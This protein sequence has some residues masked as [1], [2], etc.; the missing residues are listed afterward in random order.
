MF[1]IKYVNIMAEQELLR[2]D[3][4]EIQIGDRIESDGYFGTVLYIGS[5]A[6][7]K[8]VWL[9]VEWD[10]SNRGKHD[11]SHQGKR[12]FQTSQP[13]SGSFIRPNKVKAGV[14]CLKAIISRYGRT[15]DENAGV[16]IEDL[17]VLSANKKQTVVEMVGAKKTN[18][19]Q[20]QLDLLQEVSLRDM[21]VYGAGVTP[22]ELLRTM[23]NIE[24]LDLS[25]NLIPSW[26]AV[27]SITEQLKNLTIL[28]VS[29]NKMVLPENPE[30]LSSSFANVR[31]LIANKMKYSWENILQ[32][33][34]ICPSLE[35]L[36]VCFNSIGHLFSSGNQLRQLKLLNLES[37][38]LHSWDELLKLG[39][40][41]FLEVLIV[42][43]NELDDIYFPDTSPCE[44]SKLFPS[45]K[46]LIITHNKVSKWKSIDELNKL[47]NLEKLKIMGNPLMDTANPETVR[48]L[49]IA[50]IRNL[51]RCNGTEVTEERKGAEIDYLKRYGLDWV[52]AG[53]SQDPQKNRPSQEFTN[54]HP[55]YQELIT[56][57][58][59][60]EDSELKQ[61]ST[62]LKSNLLSVKIYC[63]LM[64]DREPVEK[65][66]PASMTVQKLKALIQ[67]LYKV[68][69]E[70]Q[71]S[72]I[73][74]K[75]HGPEIELDSD[76]RQLSFFALETGDTVHVKW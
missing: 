70:V 25:K 14:N 21:L 39:S 22:E 28:N 24:D 44:K 64:P 17:Y 6:G 42:S 23:P 45:L 12:Y 55:R 43:N 29:E 48:Q 40:L 47:Q 31:T 18:E 60:P 57:W 53:G 10:N 62:T 8:G 52:K 27:A 15:E 2:D 59:A 3:G 5:I 34:K 37:N 32:C 66:L 7:T 49:I 33:C 51:R 68:D 46:S 61:L 30:S 65:K 71:L 13:T 35:Q 4:T 50:K 54:T 63:P 56:V 1:V 72:Y 36:H 26:K 9:G 73:S 11:G 58:G 67:R 41:P 19:K 20:S 74:Q 16:I 69:S 76:L 75:M 38:R